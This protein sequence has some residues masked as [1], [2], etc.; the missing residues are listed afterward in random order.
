MK[1]TIVLQTGLGYLGHPE[2]ESPYELGLSN[3]VAR[4]Q[5]RDRRRR[6][7]LL[8][9]PQPQKMSARGSISIQMITLIDLCRLW[10]WEGKLRKQKEDKKFAVKKSG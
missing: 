2:P 1:A 5:Q 7:S 4:E 3:W 8:F 6:H 10:Q 9:I